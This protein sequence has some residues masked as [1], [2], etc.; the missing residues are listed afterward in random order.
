MMQRL[1]QSPKVVQ[2]FLMYSS[3]IVSIAF[4]SLTWFLSVKTKSV[5]NA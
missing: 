2:N 3:L 4:V 1:D 5:E